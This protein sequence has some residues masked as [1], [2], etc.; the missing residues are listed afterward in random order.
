MLPLLLCALPFEQRSALC[1]ETQS[2]TESQ[3]QNM[4]FL[5]FLGNLTFTEANEQ[6]C[7]VSRLGNYQNI[8][9]F[10]I[11]SLGKLKLNF[12]LRLV[13]SNRFMNLGIGKQQNLFLLQII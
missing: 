12:L 10:L 6:T 8:V 2:H 13:M 1:V 11:C 5:I 9:N 4:W 3:G 7:L